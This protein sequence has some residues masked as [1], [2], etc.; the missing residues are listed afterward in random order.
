FDN[1]LEGKLPDGKKVKLYT[2]D[3]LKKETIKEHK[4]GVVMPYEVAQATE[5]GWHRKKEFLS[6]PLVIARVVDLENL[7]AYFNKAKYSD[8][9]LGNFH[10]FK[11]RSPNQAQGLLLFLSYDVSNLDG[12]SNLYDSGRS[13]GVS[14]GGA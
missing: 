6:N 14:A 1:L 9:A 13:V 10:R 5:S 11:S 7:E 3:D 12:L 8:G 2:L 4:F